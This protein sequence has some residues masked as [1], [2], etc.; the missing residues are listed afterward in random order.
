MIVLVTEANLL[1]HKSENF[2]EL[3][4]FFI[5]NPT[6]RKIR[7]EQGNIYIKAQ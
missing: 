3:I 7:C 1:K 4:V 6:V 5:T 2:E